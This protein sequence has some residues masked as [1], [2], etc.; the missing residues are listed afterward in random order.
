MGPPSTSIVGAGIATGASSAA[1]LTGLGA[2]VVGLEAEERS[3]VHS[4]GRSAALFSENY[5]NEH[6]RRLTVASRAS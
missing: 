1:T 4:T 2:R 5:G 3:T 6:A